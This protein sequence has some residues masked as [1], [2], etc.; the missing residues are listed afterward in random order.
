MLVAVL[1]RALAADP[2]CLETVPPAPTAGGWATY[3]PEDPPEAL[4]PLRHAKDGRVRAKGAW[5]DEDGRRYRYADVEAALLAFGPSAPALQ[6][7][8]DGA[9][10]SYDDY[11][12]ITI[13]GAY[14]IPVTITYANDPKAE[15][16]A[17]AN[18]KG[19]TERFFLAAV[20]RYNAGRPAMKAAAARTE[21]LAAQTR[22]AFGPDRAGIPMAVWSVTET[23]YAATGTTRPSD[24]ALWKTDAEAV[25][26][27]VDAGLEVDALRARVTREGATGTLAD[28][29]TR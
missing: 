17:A 7:F 22:D 1:A 23:L 20:C 14:G 11:S 13:P 8:R 27:E 28:R 9:Q 10:S 2:L 21:A 15:A 3:D 29:L 24:P 4:V 6:A 16:E 26:R 12:S 5:Y 19:A 18:A 25:R